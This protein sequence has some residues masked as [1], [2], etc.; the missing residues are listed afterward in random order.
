[1]IVAVD[2]ASGTGKSTV[3][4]L[5]A[6]E[7]GLSYVDTGAIYR[8]VALAA[9]NKNIS[10][11]DDKALKDLCYNLKL[12]FAFKDGINRVVLDSKDVTD[13][14]R[15]PDMAMMASKVSAI[16]V[17]RASLLDMQKRL[18]KGAAKGAIVDGRDMGT[19]VFPD[20]EVKIFLTASDEVRARRRYNELKSRGMDV[21]FE[22][23]LKETI[24][25]DKQDSERTIAPLRKAPDAVEIDTNSLSVEEEKEKIVSLIRKKVT[26]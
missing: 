22:Q 7:F 1:M 26:F 23:V 18:A 12:S 20:A 19:I 10:L 25:R 8:C 11:E 2:G 21:N 13:E 17:V 5:I 14:I 9:K 6:S 15:T 24:Q 4:K 3:C 16:P